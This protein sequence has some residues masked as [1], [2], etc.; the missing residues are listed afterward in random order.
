M[1]F[2]RKDK[3]IL[4]MKCVAALFLAFM[5]TGSVKFMINMHYENLDPQLK[6][7]IIQSIQSKQSLKYL[8]IEAN[9]Q[10]SATCSSASI[11]EFKEKHEEKDICNTYWLFLIYAFVLGAFWNVKKIRKVGI[12]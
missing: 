6:E 2:L 10:S 7:E 1:M 11:L 9:N 5:F 3:V 4:S 12:V 8:K